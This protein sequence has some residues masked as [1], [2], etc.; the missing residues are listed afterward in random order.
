[1]PDPEWRRQSCAEPDL[2]ARRPRGWRGSNHAEPKRPVL[3]SWL[4]CH[5]RSE[6]RE[7][8]YND[9]HACGIAAG[10]GRRWVIAKSSRLSYAREQSCAR[11]VRQIRLPHRSSRMSAAHV[12]RSGLPRGRCDRAS[13][14]RFVLLGDGP[15]SVGNQPGAVGHLADARGRSRPHADFGTIN[16]GDSEATLNQQ[17]VSSQWSCKV[18]RIAGFELEAS[19]APLSLFPHVGKGSLVTQSTVPSRS[20]QRGCRC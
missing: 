2:A 9:D 14:D 19:N 18:L 10:R 6:R 17:A 7:R 3:L 11:R 12:P 8:E 15:E 1:M 4:D 16:S 5:V 20:P 13:V